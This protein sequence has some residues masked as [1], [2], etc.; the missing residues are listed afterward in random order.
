MS[1]FL[2]SGGLA[3]MYAIYAGTLI[4]YILLGIA[5]TIILNGLSKEHDIVKKVRMLALIMLWAF[6]LFK[7][8]TIMFPLSTMV[9][10]SNL[11]PTVTP[12]PVLPGT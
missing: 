8:F 7:C 6:V 2:N 1:N 11:S 4:W 5:G 12:L 3:V 9:N 10:L